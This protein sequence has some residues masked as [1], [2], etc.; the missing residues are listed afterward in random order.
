MKDKH[1]PKIQSTLKH[2]TIIMPDEIYSAS[3]I[4]VNGR[5]IKSLIFS[6]DLAIICNC[7]AG[8]NAITY[9]PPSTATLF[10]QMMK[11]YRL[12]NE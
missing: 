6:T 7:N 3:G 11:K 4:I 12:V 1:I 2:N 10:S 9:T 5:R 8:A